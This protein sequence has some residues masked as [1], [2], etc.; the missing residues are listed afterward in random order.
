LLIDRLSPRARRVMDL[1]HAAL[2]ALFF[3]A[4]AAGSIWI[5]LDLR[6]GNEESELLRI[7]YAPLRVVSIVAVLAVALIYVLRIAGRRREP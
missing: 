3:T 7:P 6:G 5:A 1:V 4:L 2:C